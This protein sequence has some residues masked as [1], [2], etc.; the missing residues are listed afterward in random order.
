MSEVKKKKNGSNPQNVVNLPLRCA[1]AD[2][3]DKPKRLHFC[4]EHFQWFKEGMIT[5]EGHKAKDFDKKYQAYMRRNKKA[6]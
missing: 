5:R 4:Q 1:V 6:A 2:C 3:K